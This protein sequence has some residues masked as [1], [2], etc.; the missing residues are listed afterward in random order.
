[1]KRLLVLSIAIFSFTI[2]SA[3][4]SGDFYS[5]DASHSTLMFKARHIGGGSVIGRFDSYEGTIYFDPSDVTATSATLIAEVKSINTN[6][7]FRDTVLVK[8]FF[9]ADLYPFVIFESTGSRRDGQQHYL[10]GNLTMGA[11]TKSVEIPFEYISGPTKD[12]FSHFRIT[13][14][15]SLKLNRKDYGLRY[16]SNDF[17]DGIVAN[18]VQ[19]EIESGARIYNSLETIFPFRENSIGRLAFEAYQE[20][21]SAKMKQKVDEILTNPENYITS[22]SQLLRGATHLAQSDE[23]SAAIELI[24]LGIQK[25]EMSDEW[26]AEFSARKSK[27]LLQ[28]G[29]NKQAVRVS[30]EALDLFPNSLAK[31]VIKKSQ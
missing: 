6:G 17:W 8:E 9:Q 22:K 29:K 15:G 24:D 16:R 20:G 31:E 30:K 27:H 1:M 4:V 26:K 23:V 18:E 7:G 28:L 19:I 2:S 5:I 25:I 10:L 21:G 11:F 13:L 14:G 12:Q 3:Q